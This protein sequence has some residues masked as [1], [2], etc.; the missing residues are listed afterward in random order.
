[1]VAIYLALR[2]LIFESHE[3]KRHRNK[4]KWNTA[5]IATAFAC[6]AIFWFPISNFGICF[7]YTYTQAGTAS[8]CDRM[9]SDAHN[10]LAALSSYFSYPDHTALPTVDQLIETESL[11]T[12]CPVTIEEGADGDPIIAVTDDTAKCRKGNKYV[13]YVDGSASEWVMEN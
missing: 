11:M 9:E 6:L 7:Y 12:N 13:Y 1:M 4:K 3:K 2:H 10:T 8:A 5:Q